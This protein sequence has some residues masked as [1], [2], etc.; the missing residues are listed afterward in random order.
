MVPA[1]LSASRDNRPNNLAEGTIAGRIRCQPCS[2]GRES[3]RKDR[4]LDEDEPV[5]I[6]D[7]RQD[8]IVILGR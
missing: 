2:P 4:Q 1:P 7:C 5:W 6:D 8:M 3:Y